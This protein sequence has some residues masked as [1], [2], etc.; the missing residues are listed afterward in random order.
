MFSLFLY[1]YVFRILKQFIY[2]VCPITSFLCVCNKSSMGIRVPVYNYRSVYLLLS[3]NVKSK[4][5]QTPVIQ[6]STQ[7]VRISICVWGYNH[8]PTG[9]IIAMYILLCVLLLSEN[10]PKS[11]VCNV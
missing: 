2:N 6:N 4:L 11:K 10:E 1:S 8:F 5:N 7:F 9:R 3:K